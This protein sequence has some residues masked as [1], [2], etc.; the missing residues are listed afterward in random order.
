[1]DAQDLL[2]K[3]STGEYNPE[4]IQGFFSIQSRRPPFSP[5]WIP[6]MMS[7]SRI[8]FG[9]RLIKGPILASSRFWIDDPDSSSGKNSEVKDFCIKNIVQFWRWSAV[10]ALRA[11]EWGYSGSEA[12][13]NVR[14]DNVCFESL[15]S[16]HAKD[17][18]LL[19]V[20]GEKIGINVSN[21]K[22]RR[23]R[24]YLG[25]PKGFWHTQ[26]REDHPYYGL[27]Q[28]FGAFQPYLEF[29]S[30]GGAKDIRRLYYH[31]YAFSGE[32]GYYPVGDDP[33]TGGGPGSR[34]N[35]DTMR[36][37]LEKR[38]SGAP[39]FFPGLY[40]DQGNRKWVIED[41]QPGPGNADILE[42]HRDLKTEIFEGMGI[43][44]E[45][46][47]AAT[48]GSGW[49]GRSIPQAA[50]FSILQDMVNWLIF[51]FD[52]QILRPLVTLNFGIKDPQYQIVPFGL[53]QGSEKEMK[54][55]QSNQAEEPNEAP[56]PEADIPEDRRSASQF[57]MVV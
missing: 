21:V 2:G 18:R 38:R 43:P 5:R 24:V 40:D 44:S 51:D 3:P 33:T 49:S 42:Y 6:L 30:D 27:S 41:A 7:D 14:D 32:K 9:L 53:L 25:G 28:L 13:F 11:V 46:I 52:T 17:T 23:G 22:G 15:R 55:E 39:V 1:M 26:N 50:F 37:I 34:S 36:N 35:R 8:Q 20:D 16:L 45:I 56:A 19:T 10:K 29:Y 47:E 48:V 57:S 54:Q 31:K 4:A 12:M